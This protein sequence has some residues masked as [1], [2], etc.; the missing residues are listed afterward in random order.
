MLDKR[1]AGGGSTSAST[2]LLQYEIDMPLVELSNRIGRRDAEECYRLCHDSIDSIE[3]LVAKLRVECVFQRR[4]VSARETARP[5]LYLR[6]AD[7]DRALVGGEDDHFRN[8]ARRDPLVTKRT[9]QLAK[10]FGEILKRPNA[11][12]RLFRFDR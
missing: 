1:D 12:A 10:R 9:G 7:D 2:A 3:R 8:P 4:K 11:N 6:T 5:Y